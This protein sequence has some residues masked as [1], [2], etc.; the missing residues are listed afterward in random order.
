VKHNTGLP[1][2]L[3]VFNSDFFVNKSG[4]KNRGYFFYD[5]YKCQQL[6]TIP[7]NLL[8]LIAISRN[9]SKKENQAHTGN[10]K[11]IAKK[12]TRRTQVTAK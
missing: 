2:R 12:K 10:G 8:Q 5:F 1:S 9:D 6:I 7:N 4:C 11:M 3:I